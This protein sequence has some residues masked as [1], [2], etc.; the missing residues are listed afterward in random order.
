MSNGKT[1]KQIIFTKMNLIKQASHV[2]LLHQFWFQ[3]NG[4][5]MAS[6][7]YYSDWSKHPK[8][9][10]LMFVIM[11]CIMWLVGGKACY[12]QKLIKS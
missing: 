10:A 2:R 12:L 1:E 11:R 3:A 9:C 6:T 7:S 4:D 8:T 5:V